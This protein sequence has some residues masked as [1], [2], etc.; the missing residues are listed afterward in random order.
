MSVI[1]VITSDNLQF[2]LTTEY[3]SQCKL[4]T[5]H[6]SYHESQELQV[7]DQLAVPFSLEQLQSLN[8]TIQSSEDALNL[9]AINDYLNYDG[10]QS[11]LEVIIV[12]D[13][14]NNHNYLMNE[15][16]RQ[17]GLD[18]VHDNPVYATMAYLRG[19]RHWHHSR[20]AIQNALYWNDV[21]K[22][23]V[24]YVRREDLIPFL[25]YVRSHSIDVD[26]Y[27]LVQRLG[28]VPE[29][30]PTDYPSLWRANRYYEIFNDVEHVTQANA[31]SILEVMRLEHLELELFTLLFHRLSNILKYRSSKKYSHP[32]TNLIFNRDVE[33][34]K[35]VLAKLRQRGW[36]GRIEDII[37]GGGY[38]MM[39]HRP[40]HPEVIHLLNLNRETLQSSNN[41]GIFLAVH[42][43]NVRLT[44]NKSR[45]SM[46]W[47]IMMDGIKVGI[48]SEDKVKFINY[49]AHNH[50]DLI[51]EVLEDQNR[52]KISMIPVTL[53]FNSYPQLAVLLA[54]MGGRMRLS[55][56]TGYGVIT[57]Q[58][59]DFM[60]HFKYRIEVDDCPYL[61]NWM[62]TTSAEVIAS[63]RSRMLTILQESKSKTINHTRD[64]FIEKLKKNDSLFYFKR[65]KI[66]SF[67]SQPE[68]Q[69][70]PEPEPTTSAVRQFIGRRTFTDVVM[71]GAVLATLIL[72]PLIK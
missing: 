43:S 4:L 51:V 46:A 62:K 7:S 61:L 67:T 10:D 27:Q 57:P 26:Y 56:L 42:G 55:D 48:S 69:S 40:I 37:P 38:T 31:S 28:G 12:K 19:I 8:S 6:Q 60:I 72:V 58:L 14:I 70:E 47:R 36:N 3:A 53:L 1:T 2:V 22:N 54:G 23:L 39:D 20:N 5:V 45:Y 11:E 35:G 16:V 52:D 66:E 32:L 25:D 44:F 71:S 24:D 15:D 64:K 65:Y 9:L 29:I 18:L 17:A 30:K 34:V 13:W 49:I 68:P 59:L 63:V 50:P 41:L 33:V 21:S